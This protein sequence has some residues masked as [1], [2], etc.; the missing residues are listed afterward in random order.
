MAVNYLQSDKKD[1]NFVVRRYIRHPS[2]VPIDFSVVATGKPTK[3]VLKDIGEGGLSFCSEIPIAIGSLIKITIAL[4]Q[5]P[6]AADAEVV[7]CRESGEHYEI[8]VHFDSSADSYALRM[9]EQICHI[10]QYRREVAEREGRI[11]TG[12]EA[13]AEWIA[14]YADDFPR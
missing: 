11:L 12:Q 9:V 13:A 6:F 3:R 1:Q 14:K 2:D 4:R 7:W 8:G 5:P 10:E